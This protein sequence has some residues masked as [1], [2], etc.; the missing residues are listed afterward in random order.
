MWNKIQMIDAIIYVLL[1]IT[2]FNIACY[3]FRNVAGS[4]TINAILLLQAVE[5]AWNW[6]LRVHTYVYI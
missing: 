3:T 5:C 6:T 4:K 2:V 1:T